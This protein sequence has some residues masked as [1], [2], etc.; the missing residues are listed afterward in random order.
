VVK[1]CGVRAEDM[2]ARTLGESSDE[3]M[4]NAGDTLPHLTPRDIDLAQ[5][6]Q[7]MPV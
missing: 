4:A 2:M 5:L 6:R 7:I 3:D 1:R